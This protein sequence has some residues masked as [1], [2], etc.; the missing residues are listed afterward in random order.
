VTAAVTEQYKRCL[1]FT[2][3]K[4]ACLLQTRQPSF[5]AV[6]RTK[7]LEKLPE[8]YNK[9]FLITQSCSERLKDKK[10]LINLL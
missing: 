4:Q 10:A 5:R 2:A 9:S 1:E 3:V 6:I 8:P 7:R